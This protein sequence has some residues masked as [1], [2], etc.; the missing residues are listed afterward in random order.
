MNHFV[1]V[2]C[3][4]REHTDTLNFGL[5]FL[6]HF[7]NAR[8]H[9]LTDTSRNEA[10]IDHDRIVDVK[11]PENLNHHQAS[12]FLKTS[13]HRYVEMKPG[14][15]YCY[16][17]SDV[18]AVSPKVDEIF[19]LKPEPVLFARD[20]CPFEEFSPMAMSCNCQEEQETHNREFF[21]KINR[22]FPENIFTAGQANKDKQQLE[23]AF[24]RMKEN[25]LKSWTQ[26]LLYG[27]KR[28][29]LPVKTFRFAG[30]RFNK[31]DRCWLNSK[32]EVIHFDFAYH[33][34]RVKD[35][36]GI[37]LDPKTKRWYDAQNKDISPATPA[38]NHL[39]KHIRTKYGHNIPG[40]WRHWNGGVFLFNQDSA[41]FLDYWHRITL[42]E[43]EDPA[44]KTRDQGTLAV[45][46]WHFGMQNMETLPVRFNFITE[47]QNPDTLWDAEKGYSM[48][49][50]KA[51][52]DPVFLHV[53][54]HWGDDSWDIWQSVMNIAHKN[55]IM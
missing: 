47:Y 25:K 46:A 22:Y 45:S 2:V 30:F 48:N 28:Y 5:K 54:H 24:E 16:L 1:F 36:S 29:L 39:S 18:I 8:I 41:A 43:F 13:L 4:S 40:H 26:A 32:N 11:T 35:L 53:Y 49:G 31:I 19:D 27:F 34:K 9:V 3:G 38:C 42:E 17:D 37:W 12:I 7:S 21:A 33:S 50:F 14:D 10:R 20:H 44:S 55:E 23:A 6:R 52:F 15:L 51:S